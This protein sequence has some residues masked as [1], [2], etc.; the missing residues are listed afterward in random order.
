MTAAQGRGAFLRM[1]A[2]RLPGAPALGLPMPAR[3]SANAL[4]KFA[5]GGGAQYHGGYQGA[6]PRACSSDA[7]RASTAL[8][9]A[10]AAS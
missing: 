4:S 9:R 7:S 10:S 6:A 2:A 8:S 3:A 5:T 1:L